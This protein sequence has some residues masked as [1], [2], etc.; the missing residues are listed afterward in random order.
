MELYTFLP[1]HF[2]IFPAATD[3]IQIVESDLAQQLEEMA[4][5]F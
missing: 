5:R 4:H 1:V 3:F 2:C